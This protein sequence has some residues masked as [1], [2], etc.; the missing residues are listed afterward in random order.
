MGVAMHESVSGFVLPNAWTR[1]ALRVCV[2][3]C[4]GTGSQ[5]L[6]RLAQLH[7]AL[8]A[9]EHPGGLD[10]T[11]FDPDRVAAHNLPRQNFVEA[12]I[13]ANKAELMVYR[14]NVAHGLH[15]RAIPRA[16]SHRDTFSP[17]PDIL[18]G[19]VD[20]RAARREIDQAV[21]QLNAAFWVDCGNAATQGQVVAGLG[22]RAVAD[23]PNRLPLV[24]DLFPEIA[25]GEDDNTPSCSALQSLLRQSQAVNVMAATWALAWFSQALRDGHIGWHGV[26]FDLA[27]GR[28]STIAVDPEVW[29]NLGY[30]PPKVRASR[31]Q[32][33]A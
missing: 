16:F 13:G 32:A 11:V 5:L 9:L 14:L 30:V 8:L 3:G 23:D 18:F 20:T 26:F 4:G 24:T 12:D 17:S 19:C 33:A 28:T 29:A 22:G 27:S 6:P 31:Q 21:R 7:R 2:I 1:R 15:W 10:V 25:Q